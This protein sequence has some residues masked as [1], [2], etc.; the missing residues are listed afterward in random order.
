M[1]HHIAAHWTPADCH[2]SPGGHLIG[3]SPIATRS[4]RPGVPARCQWRSGV[5]TGRRCRSHRHHPRRRRAAAPCCSRPPA[6]GPW[7]RTPAHRQPTHRQSPVSGSCCYHT[8]AW[9]CSNGC[10]ARAAQVLRSTYYTPRRRLTWHAVNIPISPP[11]LRR[12]CCGGDRICS[13]G[14][15]PLLYGE[16]SAWRTVAS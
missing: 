6:P 13:G 1:I 9:T 5:R 11:C 3:R 16:R 4:T 8:C 12:R 10:S 2:P 7:P 14:R 15:L